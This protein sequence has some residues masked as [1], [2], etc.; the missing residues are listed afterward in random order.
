VK[1]EERGLEKEKERKVKR[2]GKSEKEGKE[3]RGEKMLSVEEEREEVARDLL[4]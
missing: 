1:K 2:E 3:R 4:G